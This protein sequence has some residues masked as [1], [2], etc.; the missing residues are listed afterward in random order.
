MQFSQLATVKHRVVVG[1]PLPFNVRDVDR[2]LLLARGHVIGSHEQMEALFNRG[3]LVDMSEL[4]APAD[5]VRQAP[6]EA[7]PGL[8]RDKF[9]EVSNLLRN[10]NDAEFSAGL[11]SAT[12][13]MQALIERDKDLAIFQVL[14]QD[15][16]ALVQYGVDHSTHAA[17]TA[18]LVAQRLGWSGDDT[19]RLFKAALTMN[20]SML[21]LQGQLA[22]QTAAVS[23][24]QRAA[25][26]AH[27]EQSVR[28]L[29]LAG[30]D[31]G[32]WL[33]AVA[34][35]HERADGTGYPYG[36]RDISDIAALVQRAD[37]YTA[38]LS[39]RAGRDAMAADKAGRVMFMQDPGHPMTA[40]LVKEFG[41][42]PPGCFVRLA[43]A[44]TGVVIQRGP[45]VTTPVVAA[46]TSP[47]GHSLTEPQRRDTARREYSIVGIVPAGEPMRRMPAE[48]LM[49][50]VA[51]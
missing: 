7:L 6:A 27:P 42:Y 40:A 44:E 41:V 45:T 30:V 31:D 12:P 35:H 19:Q 5:V 2:T 17:I 34:Q 14:R 51:A 20:L 4:V 50:L 26:R 15:G 25:I 21:E 49:A 46:L 37:V 23:P 48:K 43:S 32:D 24:E 3:A 11:E 39:A 13:V 29:E 16:N 18:F 28:M 10:S 36:I 8:W 9:N 22:Q 47:T 1:A 33:R 38:K